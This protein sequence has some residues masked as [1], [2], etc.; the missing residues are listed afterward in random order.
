MK[1]RKVIMGSVGRELDE[2]RLILEF[3]KDY[4]QLR[5]EVTKCIE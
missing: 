2:A 3:A 4:M 1:T 5:M